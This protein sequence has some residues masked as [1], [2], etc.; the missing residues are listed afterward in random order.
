MIFLWLNLNGSPSPFRA[1]GVLLH[2]SFK[3]PPMKPELV[4]AWENLSRRERKKW[5]S[6]PR[7]SFDWPLRMEAWMVSVALTQSKDISIY[8]FR[9]PYTQIGLWM[10]CSPPVRTLG[11]VRKKMSG[12]WSSFPSRTRTRHFT[13]GICAPQFWATHSRALLTLQDTTLC[14][15]TIPAT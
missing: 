13:L 9:P 11:G 15:Q 14:A 5:Q 8:I 3:P 10:K 4:R 7:A 2:P 1:N 12:S 6:R